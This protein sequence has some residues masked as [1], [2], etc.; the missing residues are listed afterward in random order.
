MPVAALADDLTPADPTETPLEQTVVEEELETEGDVT[1]EP[2]SELTT[3]SL[4]DA[5]A[6]TETETDEPVKDEKTVEPRAAADNS[7]DVVYVSSTGS[8]ENGAGTQ[9]SPVATLAKAVKVARDNATI[10]VTSDLTMTKC[11]RFYNKNLTITSGDGGPYT[12]TR[13][14]DFETLADPARAW[15]NPAMI[16]VGNSDDGATAAS[17]TLTNI[18]LDDNHSV[19]GEYYVQAASK[20][21]GTEFGSMELDNRDI[22]QDAMIATYTGAGKITL[23]DGAVLKNYGGMSAVRLSGGTLTMQAGSKICD[24]SQVERTKGTTITG[25]DKSYYGPA[26]AIWIQGGTVTMEKGSLVDNMVGRAVYLDSGN[27]TVNGTISNIKA[28]AEMWYGRSGTAIHVRADGKAVLGETGVIDTITSDVHAGYTGAVMTN[29]DRN[30]G[31]SEGEG[32]DFE[33]K[34]GSVIRNVNGFPAIYSNY[35]NELLDGTVENCTNDYI[36]GGFAQVTTIGP[37]GLLQNNDATQGAAKSVVYTSNASDVYMNGTAKNNKVGTAAFYIINQSGGGAYL[38]IGEGAVIE[39][40]GDNKGVY[41]NASESKCVM[42]GG[43]ISGFNYGIDCRGKPNRDA[44]FI[45]NG[46]TITG[47]GSGVYF[48]GISNSQSIVD[49]NGGTIEGNESYE[50]NAYGGNS[51]D[52]YERVKIASGVVGGA[53]NVRLSA[54]TLTLDEGYADIQLGDAKSTADAKIKELVAAKHSDWKVASSTALWLKPSESSVH[55][56]ITA[57]SS[58][59][60]TGLFVAYIP[61]DETGAP[62]ENAELTMK[63]VENVDPIDVTLDGLTAGTSYAIMFVNNNEYTLAPDD[64]TIYTGGGQGDETYDDGG[65]PALSVAGSLDDVESIEVDGQPVETDDPMAYILGCLEVTYTDEDGVE[66][67]DDSK[68]GEYTVSLAWKGGSKPKGLRING[69][70]VADEFGT[71][72]LIVRHIEDVEGATSGDTTHEL[73]TEEP[74]APVEHAEA[75]ANVGSLGGIIK[76]D[77]KF[78]TNDDE[79]REVDAAGIQILDDKLLVDEDGTDRQALLEDKAVESGLLPELGEAE[80]YRYDF[81]YLDLV[82]AYNGNAWVSASYGTTVY[83]PYPEGVTA[84]NAEDLGLT[85]VHFKDLHREYGIAG[86]AEVEEAIKACELETMAVEYDA[87]GIKFDVAREGFSP[88][89]IVWKTPARTITVVAD[90]GSKV[91]PEGETFTVSVEEGKTFTIEPASEDYEIADVTLNGT[92]VLDQLKDGVITV[93]ASKDDQTLEVTSRSLIHTI[94]VTAGEGGTV[95]PS[96]NQTVREGEDATFTFTP[97]DGYVVADVKV[98]GE[99]VG[100][101]P[102]YTFSNVTEDHAIEVTFEEEA[103][104][105]PAHEH[106]WSD[107]KCDGE[108][109][110]KVCKTCGAISEQAAHEFGDWKLVSEATENEKGKWERTCSVCGYVQAGE[111]PVVEPGEETTEPGEET[112]GPD[113]KEIPGTG[114]STNVVVPAILG[115][116]GIAAVAGTVVLRKRGNN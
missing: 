79:D 1:E 28:S 13:S 45:M 31:T 65:F 109:H 37:N 36:I 29:G 25:A 26:G 5:E 49:I 94:T 103:V 58:V 84:E 78:Y 15:Y 90:E 110:W 18:V 80:A 59:K 4:D 8:D 87:N 76:F 95:T 71:G 74:T 88:F 63:E 67:E 86:Q 54:G 11:A 98:D 19:E 62:V 85:V 106:V 93:P 61:L 82:D 112:T 47:N 46:G 114:D 60:K 68:A 44:T 43:T 7:L 33:A 70:E 53:H 116:A 73:L 105:P 97:D 72:K 10:Y 89:A 9:E 107:W 48:N 6:E 66:A 3:L 12:V 102:S 69:N 113:D 35:G 41:I 51:E 2:S 96:D 83:L 20:G 14:A 91:T 21:G 77:P 22:V 50:I 38:E 57:P 115:A 39:G 32:Y 92:S 55:F 108:N 27:V 17:L 40:T 42:N 34:A 81:H 56:T 101:V 30:E 111:S 100:K 99:S 16:E 24:D 23:G 104:E 75:I 64:I 52:A